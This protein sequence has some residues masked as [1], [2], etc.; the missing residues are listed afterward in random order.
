MESKVKI[1]VS[2]MQIG[3][4]SYRSGVTEAQVGAEEL[5]Y[6]LEARPLQR[7]H[8]DPQ[9]AVPTRPLNVYTCNQEWN[10]TSARVPISGSAH[11]KLLTC[12][13][14]LDWICAYGQ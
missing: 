14:Q 6:G 12:R 11:V 8:V 7:G 4:C 2:Q 5:T 3:D 1:Q 10:E 13:L 9:V